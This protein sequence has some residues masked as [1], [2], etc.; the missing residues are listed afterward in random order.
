MREQTSNEILQLLGAFSQ[1]FTKYGDA[2]DKVK[3]QFDT[4]A[5]SFDELATTRRRALE[6][7]LRRIDDLRADRQLEVAPRFE[8]DPVADPGVDVEAG[9]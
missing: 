4:V 7:P 5:R 8:L 9:A 3:R 6:R 1:Q 2:V